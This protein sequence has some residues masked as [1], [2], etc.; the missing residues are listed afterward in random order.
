MSKYGDA[1]DALDQ[2]RAGQAAAVQST[3]TQFNPDNYAKAIDRSK[4]LG[5]PANIIARNPDAY[6]KP[7]K[8]GAVI[9]Q[10]DAPTT[11][12]WLSNLDN[13]AVAQDDVEN[14]SMLERSIASVFG[15]RRAVDV[16]RPIGHYTAEAARSVAS[17]I[18]ALS[19]GIYGALAAPFDVIGLD[20]VGGK[21]RG[22]QKLTSETAKQWQ[23]LEPNAGFIEQSLMSGFQ[24]AGQS[25]ALAPLGLANTVRESGTNLMLGLMGASQGGQSY[26][27]AL[28]SGLSPAQAAAYGIEDATAE[29]VTEHLFGAAGFLSL[30]KSGSSAAKLFAYE[31]AKEVPGEIGATLWQ[32]FNEWAN[33]NPEKSVSDFVAEQP[34]AI[35]QTVIATLAG[36]G[37]QIGAVKSLEKLVKTITSQDAAVSDAER[38]KKTAE[39][40]STIAQASKLAVRSPEKLEELVAKLKEATGTDSVYIE[41]EAFRTLFQ[42]EEE[43]AQAAEDLTGSAQT[44]YDA[45]VSG[46]KIPIPLEK[47]VSRIATNK[48]ALKLAESVTFSPEGVTAAEAKNIDERA[49]QVILDDTTP[50]SDTSQAVYDDVL[51]QLEKSG[52]ERSTAEKNATLTQSVFRTLASRT[53]TDAQGLYQQYGLRVQRDGMTGGTTFDQPAY[54]GSPHRFDKFDL[55]KI[56]TGEGAQAYGWGQ[57]FADAKDVAEDYRKRL[58]DYNHPGTYTWNEQ[59]F[60]SDDYKSPER[61]AIALAYH[62]GPATARKVAKQILKDAKAGAPYAIEQGGIAYAEKLLAI[63]NAIKNKKEIQFEQGQVYSVEIPDEAVARMLDWDKPLSKQ[64][65]AVRAA[66]DKLG[67]SV[68]KAKLAEFDDAL[69]SALTE[70]G[71]AV[72]PKQPD[73]PSGDDIYK[74]LVRKFGRDKAASEALRDAGIP[75]LRYLDQGSRTAKDGIHNTVI[76]DQKLLDQISEKLQKLYQRFNETKRGAIQFGKERK[77]TIS[78]LEKADLS[79]FLHESGHFYLEILGDLATDEN[80]PQQ[81]KDDYAALLKWF[82]VKSRDE[83]GVEQHEQFARGFEA[84][85]MEGKAPSVELQGMFA[86]FRAWLVGVYKTL[87]KLNVELTDNVRQV[88]DRLV[89]TDEEIQAAEESQNY[90]PIFT[91]AE[92]AGMSEREWAAYKDIAI[93]AHQEA[94][95]DM[96]DRLMRQLSREQKAWW[97]E[98]RAK[99]LDEVTAEVNQQPTYIALALLQKGTN[100]DGSDLPEGA[101]QKLNKQALLDKYGADFVKRLPRGITSKEG[102]GADVAG[103]MLGFDSGD[104]LVKALANARPKSQ[105]IEMEA[106]ARMRAKHGDIFTDG[107]MAEEAMQAVHTEGRDKVL[108]AELRAL[109][110]K[111][112]EVKPFVNAAL[113]NA[114]DEQSQARE[115]NEATLPERDELKVIKAG[116]ARIIQAKPVRDIQP[117]QYRVAE[118]KAAR[119][120]FNAAAKGDYETAYLEKRRQI[121]NHE[122]YRVA[123]KAREE[124]DSIVEYMRSFDKKATR[125]RIAKAKGQ[126]LEQ[127][128]ALRERFDFTNVSNIADL[129][130][131]ALSKWVAEQEAAGREVNVPQALLNEARRTPYKALMFAELQGLHD[132]VKNIEH[133]A[134]TKDRIIKNRKEAEWQEAKAELIERVQ[135]ALPEG[136]DPPLGRFE[137]TKLGALSD[138]AKGMADSL[139]RPETIVE[140]LDGG[141]QGPW[142]D[143]LWNQANDSED[144]RESMRERVMRPLF[145]LAQK[146]TRKRRNEL[147]EMVQI[148]SMGRSLNRRT[149]ISIALNMG[150]ESNL[151]KLKRGGYRTKD[152]SAQFTDQNLQ[153]IKDALTEEDWKFVQTVWDTVNQLWPDVV[154]F[155]KRMGGLVPEKVE[156]VPVKTKHGEFRGGYFP[157]VY[158]PTVSAQGE[159]QVAG[160]AVQ[161]IMGQNF[162]RASTKKGHT[163]ERTKI[164][165]PML[166]DFER[167]ITRH[168]DQVI[169]DLSHRE[170]VL[171]AMKILDDGELRAQIQNRIGEG[172]YRSLQGMVRHTVKADGFYGDASASGW[173]DVQDYLIR[174]TAVAAL[175]FRAVTAFGNLVLAPVQAAARIQPKA[176]L[177]GIGE[178]YR[179]PKM[180]TEFIHSQSTFM[181]NRAENFDQSIVETMANLRGERS[182]RAQVA[183]AAMSVHRWADFLGTHGLWLGKYQDALKSGESQESAVR[184]ADKAIRQTQTAGAPKDLSAFER[185]PRYK[186]FRMFFGPMAIMGDRIRDAVERKGVVKNWPE[187]FGT[188]MAVWFVPAL[189]WEIATGKAP[190]DEDDDGITDDAV[191]WALRKIFFYPF[192]TLPF[193]RDIA[194]YAERRINGQYAASRS[195]PLAEAGELVWKA[196]ERAA[197]AGIALYEGDEV[198]SYKLTKDALRASGPLLG[199]PSTQLDVTG[200]YLYDVFSG[201]YDPE[202]VSDLSYLFVRRPE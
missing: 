74:R 130:R 10:M 91:N 48:N 56:G 200:T 115:A 33:V 16:A 136:K 88:M 121:L 171:Q 97:K 159:K 107:S 34:E 111:R 87:S 192:M 139:L 24:S 166:L 188:L 116:V 199:M 63:A 183:R 151:D 165:R 187:A 168:M 191:A 195:V 145:D 51:T 161:E 89:A 82:G 50:V 73:N 18:P 21:L 157:V 35:G 29:I 152:G 19:S 1:I 146:I 52:M 106:D 140:W 158:D 76:W 153:E 85:L 31:L 58:V 23:G 4:E 137:Q 93:R 41:P 86:R 184:E 178:F 80:A 39:Q 79:T 109:S 96:T 176:I 155:Q 46:T 13:A 2:D 62:N 196:G 92:Q 57:Y 28:E 78:L 5:V 3:A 173:N 154:E 156:A 170:F 6:N 59:R 135:S 110:K 72:L 162:T 8:Y 66:L 100:P 167:V 122:L 125:E 22:L 84:Y 118:A 44:Y 40:L 169:T 42:S 69:L 53:G 193:L 185:D 129:K 7:S 186:A 128:D 148:P 123:V 70:D 138:K 172:A 160:D 27:K 77:F 179:S 194:N 90:A 102:I 190:D 177:K 141:T 163:K 17:G 104:A 142:H 182:I 61:H 108:A 124:V 181:K 49:A 25:L 43:A 149:L 202:G 94:T 11:H 64:S 189:V 131:D 67:L 38:S 54:H 164:A 30:V 9:D 60:P 15:T 134:R 174:N 175:G 98:E 127:I 68:D 75:G 180:M 47:Y 14:L 81:V 65:P 95:Q 103:Q 26:T 114:K 132:A 147:Q 120:A 101:A 113:K 198:E 150:N 119:K 83:I 201:E 126:Y 12:E 55:S 197:K 45:A 133:L 71:D 20:S 105:L 36:G 117:N 37:A 143:Y 32:N 144:R 112:R 99:V